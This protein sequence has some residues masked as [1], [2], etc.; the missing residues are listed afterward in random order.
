MEHEPAEKSRERVLV[1]VDDKD[2]ADSVREVLEMSGAT[3]ATATSAQQVE[4]TLQG[5]FQPSVALIDVRPGGGTVGDGAIA[6]LRSVTPRL[7]VRIVGMSDD[8][9]VLRAIQ[10][11]D[12]EL[13]KPFTADELVGRVMRR[14][15]T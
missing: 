2:L 1:V 11:A 8:S 13:V 15:S 3:V 12:E 10:G 4:A 9:Q 5:G 7:D 14:A 6:R